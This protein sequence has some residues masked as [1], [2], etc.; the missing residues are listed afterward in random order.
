[1]AK[2]LKIFAFLSILLA[3]VQIILCFFG[4]IAFEQKPS[5]AVFPLMVP[6]GDFDSQEILRAQVFF[7]EEFAKTG[8]FAIAGKMAIEEYIQKNKAESGGFADDLFEKGTLDYFE[9]LKLAKA[10]G[11]SRF[12]LGM[13]SRTADSKTEISIGIFKTADGTEIKRL[14]MTWPDLDSL[15]SGKDGEG[16]DFSVSDY[17]KMEFKT[18]TATDFIILALFLGQGFFGAWVIYR[19]KINSLVLE[20]IWTAAFLLFLFSLLYAQNAN[21]DYVQRFIAA[22]GQIHL[23]ESTAA[24]QLLALARYAPLLLLYGF[25]YVLLRETGKWALPAV[26]FSAL[27]Y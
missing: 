4:P 13:L 26:L 6:T 1:M 12:S 16:N 5:L 24:E 17:F 2:A 15:L 21:M 22:R 7:E 8:S 18:Y 25:Y 10:L 14:K 27:L 23:A 19:K 20:I 3:L 9:S 11:F